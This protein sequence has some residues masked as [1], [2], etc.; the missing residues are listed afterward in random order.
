MFNKLK[1]IPVGVRAAIVYT[2]ASVFSRG[3]AMITV[4]IFTR[5]MST[6]EIGMVNLYNSWHSLIAVVAT[7]SL[8]SG[9]FQ[10]AMKDFSHERDQ[11]QSSVLTLTSLMALILTVMYFI[12]PATWNSI[13]GLPTELMVLMLV[14]FFFAPA[15]DFWL[16]RQRYEFK[17]KL[18][19]S[20]TIGISVIA[21][22]ISVVTVL[23]L[24]KTGSNK[25]AEG[26]L[27]STNIVSIFVAIIIWIIIYVRGKK[28]VSLKYWKYSFALS[29]PL[30][31][32]AIANQI[33]SVSDRMMISK[34]VGNDAVGIYSTLYTVS[35]ISLLIWTAINSSFVPYLFQTIGKE[36][37]R[38]GRISIALMGSYAVLALMLT[39]LA[40][41]IV[42]ILATKEYY[43]AIYIMP[44][45]AAGV[46]LTSVSNM[47]SNL[48]IYYKSTKYIMY[49]SATAAII[50][51]VLN[52]IFINI[53]GYIA[54][55]YTTLFAY[56]VLAI[57]QAFFARKVHLK[58]SG[59][60]S[61]YNDK[62]VFVMVIITI[63]LSLFGLILY[64]FTILRYFIVCL[65]S[66]LG[67]VLIKKSLTTLK[68]SK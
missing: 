50:N 6:S 61:V 49:S 21:T 56:I 53:F 51:V 12:S 32:Y 29:L 25:V 42:R 36:N 20:V 62:A 44:P 24:D 2:F 37:N 5:I 18:A 22:L 13:T 8:T 38:I 3:L 26:R 65:G 14:S 63:A 58:N 68:Q 40:P 34:M 11:Y 48:L 54:A 28:V 59:D 66:I 17:Y 27:F 10:A 4:P 23:N 41:E 52:L 60:R 9:G 7:L 43:E 33:L 64:H 16:L 39:Y 31:G 35:S 55:A 57:L 47:Y 30:V 19:C 15:Q 1:K 46:F 67:V 45:I